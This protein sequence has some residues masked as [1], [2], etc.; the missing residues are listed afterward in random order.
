MGYEGRGRVKG[1]T[2]KSKPFSSPQMATDTSKS[3]L[4]ENILHITYK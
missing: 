1:E 2:E 3:Y 4:L